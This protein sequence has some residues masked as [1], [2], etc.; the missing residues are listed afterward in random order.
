MDV[1]KI[2]RVL[3]YIIYVAL[4]SPVI[5]VGL[6]V[7]PVVWLVTFMRSGMTVKDATALYAL[8]LKAGFQHDANFIKTGIW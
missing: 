4:W 3:G 1:A 5:A 7:L 2:I 6:V 8:S